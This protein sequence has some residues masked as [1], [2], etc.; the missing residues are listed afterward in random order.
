MGEG[1]LS[2][3]PLDAGATGSQAFGLDQTTPPAVLGVQL[4]DGRPWGFSASIIRE[5]A[6]HEMSPSGDLCAYPI[7]SV[8]RDECASLIPVLNL[9]LSLS[10]FF[11]D[12]IFS[13]Y[14]LLGLIGPLP[15]WS[16]ELKEVW[17]FLF[18][19]VSQ[20]LFPTRPG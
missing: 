20:V 19:S 12:S 15:L 17:G 3:L 6:P 18:F 16:A 14:C 7:G 1:R 4:A 8:S 10:K 11:M 5:P 9:F 2:L 13:Q